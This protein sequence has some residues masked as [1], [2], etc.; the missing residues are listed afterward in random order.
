MMCFRL[1]NSFFLTLPG[2][3]GMV[4]CAFDLFY[5]DSNAYYYSILPAFI[6]STGSEDGPYG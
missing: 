2:G 3:A 1:L 5:H 4:N 6:K